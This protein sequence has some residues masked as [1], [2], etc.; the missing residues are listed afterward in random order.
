ME[1]INLVSIIVISIFTTL[2][3]L[4]WVFFGVRY[5]LKNKK[6]KEEV[7]IAEK[8]SYVSEIENAKSIQI[9]LDSNIKRTCEYCTIGNKIHWEMVV[10]NL[11]DKMTYS[12]ERA[13]K[14]NDFYHF[15]IWKYYEE[16]IR[17]IQKEY[18]KGK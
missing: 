9:F 8:T 1:T 18:I 3:L 2:I 15:I 7:K 4:E 11:K 5:Y 16:M 14:E 13:T 6:S 17:T 10:I 12:R